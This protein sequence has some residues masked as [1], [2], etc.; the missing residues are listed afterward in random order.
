VTTTITFLYA[1]GLGVK[2]TKILHIRKTKDTPL[3]KLFYSLD[4]ID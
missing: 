2:H 4:D 1:Y 3:D